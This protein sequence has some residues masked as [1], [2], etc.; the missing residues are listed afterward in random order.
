MPEPQRRLILANGEH[1]VKTVQ[2][3][4]GFPRKEWSRPYEEARAHVKSEIGAALERFASLPT[5]KRHADEAVLCLRLH[6]DLMAKSYEPARVL[7]TVPN[8][9]E[10]G[11]R[12]Y[13]LPTSAV[14]QTNSIKKQAE[15]HIQM[16][17]GRMVFVRGKDSDFKGLL[18]VLEN[19]QRGLNETFCHEVQSIERFDL[20]TAAEQVQGFNFLPRWKEGRVEM[21]LHPSRHSETEQ[22][23][24]LRKLFHGHDVNWGKTHVVSYPNG[25][26]FISCRLTREALNEIAG[27]NPLRAAHP[28]FFDG[29]EDLRSGSKLTA[30]PP[31][32]TATR[33]TIKVGIFDGGVDAQNPLLKGHVEQ[34]E[35]RSIKT[36]PDARC[37]AHGTAVAGVMLYGPLNQYDSKKPLPAPPVSVVSVRVLPTSDPKDID[38]YECINVIE[39]TVPERTDVKFWNVSF[40]PRGPVLDDS[41]S[42]F[43]YA[44]DELS[45]AHKTGFAVAVGNDGEAGSDMA[46]IQ[47]PSDLVNGL[48]VGAFTRHNGKIRHASYSC[49]GPGR[50]CGKPKP[51]LSAYGGCDMAPIHLVASTHGKRVLAKGTSFASP[52]VAS[53]GG[54]IIG[55]VERGTALLAR[56][57]MIHTAIHPDGKW[58]HFL[59]HGVIAES[60]DRIVRC[61]DKE[62]TMLFQGA[63]IPAKYVKLPIMLPAGTVNDG[64]VEIR[65]TVAGL[66]PVS[67][68]HPADYTTICIEDTFYPNSRMSSYTKKDELGKLISHQLH[69][70]DDAAEIRRLRSEGGWKKSDFPVSESRNTYRMEHER[71]ALD[72]K[73]EPIVK[74]RMGKKAENLHEPFLL[75]HAI[76]RHNAA[77]RLDYA[78]VVTISAQKFSGDLY[79]EILRRYPALQQVRLRTETELRVRIG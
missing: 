57:I 78:A 61:D 33:S 1:Y 40:G 47:A 6:P 50:E 35:G 58:D 21:V 69:E 73:W 42:R 56:A 54:Q 15:A 25:P 9:T 74:R 66:P 18:R 45:V 16:A 76:P 79:T 3:S 20:L 64:R 2:K 34:D 26:T 48:G 37:V 60:L 22:T 67:A 29:L 17:T 65:W 62:V 59:G 72:L 53:L 70:K 38:L 75:L 8:L 4:G 13:H 19:A 77:E 43:T 23:N 27:A 28:L 41:I 52:P 71:R 7:A 24:F 12:Y 32:N 44:L 31:P 30:P 49:Q 68:N 39:S 5:R 14:A 10:I 36:T 55:S 11:S 63:L 51:D 46:R